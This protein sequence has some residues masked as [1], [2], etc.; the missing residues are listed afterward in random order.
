MH[1]PQWSRH[2]KAIKYIV[3]V[4]AI[5]LVHIEAA[6]AQIQK[7]QPPILS[8]QE[9]TYQGK[10]LSFWLKALRERNET[11][12]SRAFEAIHS[13]EEDAWVAVPDLTRL[14]AAPFEPIQVGTDSPET[15]A[16]KL[17]DI[18]VRSEAIETLVWIGEPSASASAEGLVRWAL[19]ERLAA[20]LTTRNPEQMDL[21]IELVAMDAEQRMRVAGALASFGPSTIRLIANL[22]ASENAAERKLGVAILSQDALPVATE[23]LHS[24]ACDDRELGLQILKDMNVVVAQSYI[25]VLTSRIR[26]KCSVLTKVH[27]R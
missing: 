9:R 21:Y 20:Q 12:L 4:L 25:D 2:M 26:E 22:I 15:V 27:R 13:L 7:A 8:F 10:P 19:T 23:L 18:A 6:P 14:V 3:L 1:L 16:S 24:E 17:Y 5:L 11:L